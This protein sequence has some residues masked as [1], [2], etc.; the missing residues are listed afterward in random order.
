MT[1]GTCDK[2]QYEHSGPHGEVLEV[3]QMLPPFPCQN[4]KPIPA[5]SSGET[6][7]AWNPDP[8]G[9]HSDGVTAD[10][11]LFWINQGHK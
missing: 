7:P 2:K 11:D 3:G 1:L 6:E 9:T 8:K 10:G 4:W 5:G